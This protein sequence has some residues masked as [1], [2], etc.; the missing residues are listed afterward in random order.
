MS[1]KKI[2]RKRCVSE[3]DDFVAMGG[4]IVILGNQSVDRFRIHVRLRRGLQR[5]AI[6]RHLPTCEHQLLLSVAVNRYLTVVN[7]DMGILIAYEYAH[8]IA[9][10]CS[11]FKCYNRCSH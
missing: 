10:Y 1:V 6:Q 3:I 5:T 8:F 7:A 4:V 9:K 2:C 11:P